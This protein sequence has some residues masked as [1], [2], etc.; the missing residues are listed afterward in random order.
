MKVEG[1]LNPNIVLFVARNDY[2]IQNHHTREQIA[3]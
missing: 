2:M 1:H 3:H